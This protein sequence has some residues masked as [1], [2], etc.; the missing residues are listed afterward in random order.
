MSQ[1][2]RML[3][4]EALQAREHEDICWPMGRWATTKQPAANTLSLSFLSNM[5]E[6]TLMQARHANTLPAFH[7]ASPSWMQTIGLLCCLSMHVNGGMG[8][9]VFSFLKQKSV[10]LKLA[11]ALDIIRLIC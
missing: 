9:F 6:S 1:L 5:Y 4:G 11:P 10:Q 7:A 3:R 8:V 2:E